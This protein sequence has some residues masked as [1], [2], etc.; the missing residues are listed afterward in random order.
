[1]LPAGGTRVVGVI[2]WRRGPCGWFSGVVGS[3][4]NGC[5]L[6]ASAIRILTG[7]RSTRNG[8]RC[9]G[10]TAVAE[11]SPPRVRK[12]RATWHLANEFGKPYSF[13]VSNGEASGE[14]LSD[15][16]QTQQAITS[17]VKVLLK[18]R[19]TKKEELA[20]ALGMPPS[21]LS[22]SLSEDGSRRRYWKTHEVLGL[23]RFYTVSIDAFYGDPTAREEVR[24]ELRALADQELDEEDL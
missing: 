14:P 4:S 10:V 15:Q 17:L 1:M 12:L 6:T 7:A 9:T 18:R 8:R 24:E 2:T 13:R 5:A 20:A 21:S 19:G 3:A 16:E 22:H 23:S 11:N